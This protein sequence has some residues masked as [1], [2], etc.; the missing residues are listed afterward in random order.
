MAENEKKGTGNIC[1][2]QSFAVAVNEV[3]KFDPIV[4]PSRNFNMMTMKENGQ[5]PQI[6]LDAGVGGN[7]LHS[8]FRDVALSY[9][10]PMYEKIIELGSFDQK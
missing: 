9:V 1:L 2:F 6:R 10:L 8:D 5:W 7:W 4:G 3:P